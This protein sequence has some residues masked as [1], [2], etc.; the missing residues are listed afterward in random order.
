[1]TSCG[2]DTGVEI[3]ESNNLRRGETE[4]GKGWW[5]DKQGKAISRG[6]TVLLGAEES[7]AAAVYMLTSQIR[8][9][10]EIKP[11]HTGASRQRQAY[12]WPFSEVNF[13]LHYCPTD[14]LETDTAIRRYRYYCISLATSGPGPAVMVCFGSSRGV[15]LYKPRRHE[16]NVLLYEL[17]PNPRV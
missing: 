2:R 13:L 1:M 14:D 6:V 16:S 15:L 7:P 11:C 9:T 3:G 4:L 12:G 10:N 5:E 8:A 17:R